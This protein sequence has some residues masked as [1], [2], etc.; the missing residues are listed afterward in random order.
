MPATRPD[1]RFSH[2][3]DRRPLGRHARVRYAVIG[4]GHI[5]QA[6]VLPAF[7]R[8]RNSELAALVSGD[9]RKLDE[10]GDRYKVDAR[11]TYRD[12]EAC[13]AEEDIDAVY[14]ATPN[15][16]HAEYVHRAARAGVHVLCEKPLGMTEG[17]CVEMIDACERHE[18]LLMT[19]YRLH[20]EP[21][22][23]KALE[24]VRE[25]EI[26]EPR[27]FLSAFSYQIADP[28]N[29]RLDADLGGG[30]LY[31]IGV[32]CINAAR[33][34]FGCEPV[35]VQAWTRRCPDGRFD[36]VSDTITAH[37]RFPGDRLA[38]FACS[39]AL[40]EA[41]W[42]QVYGTRG[43]VRVEPAYEYTEGLGLRITVDGKTRERSFSQRDQFAAEIQYFSDCLRSGRVPE[44]SGAEGLADV[45]VVRALQQ[46]IARDVAL[47]LPPTAQT[48]HP[49]P[50][51]RI[52][53]PAQR[54]EPELVNARSASS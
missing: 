53:R 29:I 34:I 11:Y 8:A 27:L 6:A 41:S 54:K 46:S 5:A 9:P 38:M 44:P 13:L 7:R 50:D 45:R 52:E 48:R 28:Q 15:T 16:E 2:D 25:G 14:I 43:D 18:V 10:L 31:D 35:E 36:E 4:L 17:E 26:G 23:L 20:F 42:Y 19:A 32:Y 47:R 21:A 49:S 30:P 40:A 3:D 51:Q 39:F 33:T 37:L 1:E 12:L 24:I 22:N